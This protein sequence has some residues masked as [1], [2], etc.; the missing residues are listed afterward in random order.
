MDL[1]NGLYAKPLQALDV[2]SARE[3]LCQ[4]IDGMYGV[5]VVDYLN[6]GYYYYK[7][8]YILLE[9]GNSGE[10]SPSK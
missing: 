10:I 5:I 9:L 3:G 8:A 1:A 4:E 2:L 6:A 7:V